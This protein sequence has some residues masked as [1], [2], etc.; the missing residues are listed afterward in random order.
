MLALGS[1]IGTA[2]LPAAFLQKEKGLALPVLLTVAAGVPGALV[3][4][5]AEA[6][7]FI[8]SPASSSSIPRTTIG[9][10]PPSQRSE[11]QFCGALFLS[12]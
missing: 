9:R 8:H 4:T 7:G 10:A 11:S 6:A 5:L 12:S 2:A 3:L 1:A